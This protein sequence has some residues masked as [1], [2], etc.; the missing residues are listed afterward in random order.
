MKKIYL[1]ILTI[2]TIVFLSSCARVDNPNVTDNKT[3]DVKEEVKTKTEKTEEIKETEETKKVE[4]LNEPEEKVENTEKSAATNDEIIKDAKIASDISD[5]EID[6]IV[7]TV[8]II[9]DEDFDAIKK[10][11]GGSAKKFAESNENLLDQGLAPIRISGKIKKILSI[12]KTLQKDNDGTDV[13]FYTVL[14]EGENDNIYVNVGRNDEN[15]LA[16]F[17]INI[18]S[19]IDNQE[20]LQKKYKALI[21]RTFDIIKLI[22]DGKYEEFMNETTHIM[23]EKEEIKKVYD[24]ALEGFNTSGKLRGDKCRVAE[25]HLSDVIETT[26]EGIAIQI[27]IRLVAENYSAIDFQLF[28]DEDGNLLAITYNRYK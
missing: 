1:M 16:S 20:A 24:M 14:C 27:Y 7:N 18:A 15:K 19:V 10:L 13:N 11:L 12:E 26:K 28:F 5:D 2:V 4:K 8:K 6:W 3:E 25:N 17:Q 23:A 9:S 21:D 22:K